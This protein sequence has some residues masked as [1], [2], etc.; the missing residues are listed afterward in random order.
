MKKNLFQC[1]IL[2]VKNVVVVLLVMLFA[3][4]GQSV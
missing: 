2:D 3:R 1:Y 4:K